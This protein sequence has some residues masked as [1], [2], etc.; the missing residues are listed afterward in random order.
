M[1]KNFDTFDT[2]MTCC[3]AKGLK[4]TE[5]RTMVLRCLYDTQESQTA[6]TLLEQYRA[7]HGT[8]EAMTIYR[9][10]DY[11][12][13]NQLVHK[14]HSQNTYS[15]CDISHTHSGAYFFICEHCEQVKEIHTDLLE[16]AFTQ[17][18]H[19]HH[20]HI[21]QST[22]ELRGTCQQCQR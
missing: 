14:I 22:L 11:L 6:Y 7:T 9:A 4:M 16:N 15:L 20:F 18:A 12:E 17:I 2:F 10:L 21:Q 8:G 3:L 5:S 19:K 1:K 13:K